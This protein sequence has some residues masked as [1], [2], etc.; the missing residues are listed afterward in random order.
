MGKKNLIFG[1]TGA[2]GSPVSK[3][4]KDGSLEAHLV[5]KNEEEVSRLADETGF[6]YSVADVLEEN[7]VEKIQQ[8][9]GET[10]ISGIAYCVGSINFKPINL[11]RLSI[12]IMSFTRGIFLIVV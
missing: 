8:D 12:V 1:A 6:K 4:L 3:L 2:V 11:S 10:D 7:F 9:L 5:G